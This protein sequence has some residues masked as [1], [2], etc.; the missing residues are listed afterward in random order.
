MTLPDL[1]A[2]D[3]IIALCRKRGV[4]VIKIDNM[5]LTL[6]DEAPSTRGTKGKA[7]HG[8]QGQVET[9]GPSDEDMLYWSAGMGNPDSTEPESQ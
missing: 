9:D 7:T 6:S 8:E 4:K 2:L 1:K 5:E 3:K